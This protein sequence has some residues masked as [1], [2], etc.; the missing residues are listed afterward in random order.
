L[1]VERPAYSRKSRKTPRKCE[2]DDFH[3]FPKTI[4][5]SGG[6]ETIVPNL[7]P[8][9]LRAPLVAAR[10]QVGR[11][12]ADV[13][14]AKQRAYIAAFMGRLGYKEDVHVDEFQVHQW[15]RV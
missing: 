5:P 6:M 9:A 1:A 13:L 12:W 8:K 7:S 2:I 10:A 15:L 11:V 3:T 4:G 14:T